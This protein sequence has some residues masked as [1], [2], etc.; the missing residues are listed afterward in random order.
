MKSLCKWLSAIAIVLTVSSISFA[1]LPSYLP[2]NGLVAWYPFNGNA[3]DESGNGNGHDGVVN[4]ATLTDDRFGNV[5]SAYYLNGQ[6]DYIAVPVTNGELQPVNITVAAWC[7]IPSDYTA[8]NGIGMLV[9]SRYFGYITIYD[10][11]TQ[12]LRFETY[13][14]G[15]SIST[16]SSSSGVD[17]S[18]V[19]APVS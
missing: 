12:N 1:Q 8:N 4:G 19:Q 18:S 15:N 16:A 17:F 7:K 2:S 9:R 5:L 10:N 11:T 6:T 3:N 13:S 14:N